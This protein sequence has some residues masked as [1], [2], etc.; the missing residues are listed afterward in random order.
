MHL[1][2]PLL[3]CLQHIRT[4]LDTMH[5]RHN[6]QFYQPLG[7]LYWVLNHLKL[8]LMSS[9]DIADMLEPIV[10]KSH[11]GV[12]HG[13]KDAATAIVPTDNNVFDLRRNHKHQLHY[14]IEFGMFKSCMDGLPRAPQLHTA[15]HSSYSSHSPVTHLQCFCARKPP[16]V[17]NP[18]RKSLVRESRC[19]LSRG[20]EEIASWQERE[21]G[22]AGGQIYVEPRFGSVAGGCGCYRAQRRIGKHCPF[23]NW[24]IL[25]RSEGF[26]F[27]KLF[28]CVRT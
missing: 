13:S 19:I 23:C 12:A 8:L 2:T 6:I 7:S 10:Y 26:F 14:P 28:C 3:H 17:V 20:Y 9:A 5:L 24:G 27:D 15:A 1:Q 21:R 16:P 25:E 22:K 18:T 11:F 4:P